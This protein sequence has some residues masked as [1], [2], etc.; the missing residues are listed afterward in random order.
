M[1]KIEFYENK[2]GES[3]VWDFLEA[4]REKSQSS[5][6]ARIQYNQIIFYIDLL[7]KNGTNLPVN[8]TKHLEED[9]WELRPGNN[10][11]FYFYYDESQYVLLHHFRKK[12]QKTPK[13]EITRAKA[14]R[15]DYI[16]QKETEQ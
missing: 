9:I 12:S 6:D 1:Y 5:K 13:R 3:E 8:I 2:R 11:V 15:D 14:E 10:R 7:A 16:R 4:L